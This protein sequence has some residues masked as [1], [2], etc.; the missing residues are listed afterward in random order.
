MAG[1]F[2]VVCSSIEELCRVGKVFIES[3][4]SIEQCWKYVRETRQEIFIKRYLDYLDNSDCAIGKSIFDKS[5]V[6]SSSSLKNRGENKHWWDF[7]Q[8]NDTMAYQEI[9]EHTASDLVDYVSIEVSFIPY[10]CDVI[11]LITPY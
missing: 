1:L 2:F 5:L 9:Y 6:I 10:C 4:G 8:D 3:G 7:T 11:P